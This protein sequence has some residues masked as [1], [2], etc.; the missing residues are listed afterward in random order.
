MNNKKGG[1]LGKL[2]LVLI[3]M[4]ASA[5]GGAYAYRIADGKLAAKDATKEINNFVDADDYDSLEAGTVSQCI[6][7]AIKSLDNAQTREDV[8][9]ILIDFKKDIDKIP[10]TAEKEAQQA[11]KD[12]QQSQN[13]QNSQD[14]QQDDQSS[15]LTGLF[16]FTNSDDDN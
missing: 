11:A 12:A 7:D 2:V 13:S 16:N 15:G 6:E 4:L 10:T 1:F 14:N 9:E 8:Y 5:V 3:L